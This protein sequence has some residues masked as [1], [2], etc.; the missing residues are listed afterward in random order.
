MSDQAQRFRERA[1]DCRALSKCAAN[2]VDAAM[3]EEVADELDAEAAKLDAEE[4]S[5]AKPT[6]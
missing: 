1:I 2:H 5:G 3:L 6:G 4:A